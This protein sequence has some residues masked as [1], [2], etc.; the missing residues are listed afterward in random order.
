MICFSLCSG[1]PFPKGFNYNQQSLPLK[2]EV[3]TW[4]LGAFG[5]FSGQQTNKFFLMIF[6]KVNLVTMSENLD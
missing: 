1:F 4:G 2:K 3:V 6:I 5:H